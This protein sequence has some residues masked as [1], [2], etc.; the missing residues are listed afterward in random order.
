MLFTI[1]SPAWRILKKAI[2]YSGF[3]NP[4][5]KIRE[6]RKI[7][8]I[9]KWHFVEWKTEGRKPDENSSLK[10]TRCPEIS[11]KNAVQEFHLRTSRDFKA[12]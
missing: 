12:K 10:K 2:L 5:E 1:P 9:Y 8:S 11:T 7:E 3:N 6:T 4:K